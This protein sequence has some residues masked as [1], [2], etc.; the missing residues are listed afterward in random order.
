MFCCVAGPATGLQMQRSAKPSLGSMCSTSRACACRKAQNLPLCCLSVALA[1]MLC[2][3]TRQC[4]EW[5]LAGLS[6]GAKPAAWAA[7]EGRQCF[8]P[9]LHQAS[10]WGHWCCRPNTA[11]TKSNSASPFRFEAD[12][13]LLLEQRA[14]LLVAN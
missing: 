13:A 14:Y 12:S 7:V 5:W 3:C 1:H 6:V 8:Q 11:N 9:L 4:G 2:V 10:C